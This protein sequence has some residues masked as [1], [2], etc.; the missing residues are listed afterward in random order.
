M[1]SELKSKVDQYWI[2]HTITKNVITMLA[3][4]RFDY[5]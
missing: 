4:F 3:D 1:E 2:S 5:F